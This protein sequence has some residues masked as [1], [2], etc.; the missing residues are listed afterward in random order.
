[1]LKITGQRIETL[2]DVSMILFSRKAIRGGLTFR[3][4]T[5]CHSNSRYLPG[6]VDERKR[7]ESQL[8]MMDVVALY[9]YLMENT[10]LAD[11]DYTWVGKEEL[12]DLKENIESLQPDS[13][14]GYLIECDISDP[15]EIHDKFIDYPLL[16]AMRKIKNEKQEKL[17]GNLLPKKRIY[18]S[19]HVNCECRHTWI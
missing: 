2:P 11:G 3:T 5:I 8:F 17:I 4:K 16:P 1:M 6:R 12:L 7:S 19:L 10:Y 15:P 14:F 13:E 9:S 18:L